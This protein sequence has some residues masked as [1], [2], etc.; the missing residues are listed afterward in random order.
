[1]DKFFKLLLITP[2]L[3]PPFQLAAQEREQ[4]QLINTTLEKVNRLK[5]NNQNDSA[6]YELLTTAHSLKEDDAQSGY[7]YIEAGNIYFHLK[8]YNTASKFYKRANTIFLKHTDLIGQAIVLEN[9]GGIHDR[10][11]QR[12]SALFYYTRALALQQQAGDKFYAAH[13]QRAIALN[14]SLLGKQDESKKFIRLALQSINDTDITNHP[15][16]TWDVQFIPQQVYLSASD[17]FKNEKKYDS[18]EFYL[19]E[20]IRMTKVHGIDAH[21]VRYTTFLATFY[22]EQRQYP[23]AFETIQ[24]ALLLADS[25]SYVWGKVGAL[26]VLRNYYHQ[27]KDAKKELQAGYEYLLYKDKMYNEQNNDE[28]IVMSNLVLQYE[29]E[30]EIARQQSLMKEQAKINQLQQRENYLLLGLSAVFLLALISVVYLYRS[31][32]GKAKQVQQYSEDLKTSNETMRMLLSVIS[33][34][35]RSPFHSL[36]GLTKVTLMEEQLSAP[37][38]RERVSMMH[39]TASKGSI[40]LDNLLQWVALQRDKVLIK[41]EMVG[42]S[43]LVEETIQELA[44]LALTQNVT[45]ERNIFLQNY[46]TDKNALKVIIRNMLTNAIKY[47]KGLKVVVSIKEVESFVFI[48][49]TDQGP[50]IPEELLQTLFV[51]GDMKKVA[52]KG[53]GLGMMIVKDFVTQLNGQIRALNLPEG[54]ARFEVRL[55]L[56]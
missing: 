18:A 21:R 37:E 25:I 42:V 32:Q 29:N 24:R 45:I 7:L 15:R 44:N 41:K 55:P 13:S 4:D 40:L 31:L 5:T 6:L 26:Q 9:Y 47:S 2:F 53:G 14:Y 11:L 30:L 49:V 38:L 52:A 39:D 17:I 46:Y 43:A 1:M 10:L 56:Q 54:G 22:L 35:L 23:K 51:Q 50:G 20:A 33:H 48:H 16:Y 28:L 36:I 27:T 19:K 8:L 12:D 3:M 34:D